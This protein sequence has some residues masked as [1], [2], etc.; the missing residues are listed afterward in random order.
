MKLST[1]SRLTGAI[2]DSREAGTRNFLPSLAFHRP[3]QSGTG[4][5]AGLATGPFFRDEVVDRCAGR[6]TSRSGG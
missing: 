2:R 1:I 6:P 3:D 5:R 4:T